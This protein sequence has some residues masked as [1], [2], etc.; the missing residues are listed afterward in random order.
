MFYGPECYLGARWWRP[1]NRG[2]VSTNNF[3]ECCCPLKFQAIYILVKPKESHLL[4]GIA[5]PMYHCLEIYF[6]LW[7][8]DDAWLSGS[9]FSLGAS[10]LFSWPTWDNA[11][12]VREELWAIPETHE[13]PAWLDASLMKAASFFRT[14][15]AYLEEIG[16]KRESSNKAAN[17]GKV[18]RALPKAF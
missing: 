9:F 18:H 5:R 17:V 1:F 13:Q 10:W 3:R 8:Q 7:P 14:S 15:A 12:E 16:R 4:L 6:G 2:F 11:K